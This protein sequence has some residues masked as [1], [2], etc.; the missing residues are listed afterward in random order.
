MEA[1]TTQGSKYE[2]VLRMESVERIQNLCPQCL[3]PRGKMLKFESGG[4]GLKLALWATTGVLNLHH[5]LQQGIIEKSGSL[6]YTKQ[7]VEIVLALKFWY[8]KE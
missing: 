6:A 8:H 5:S 3:F 2:S 4:G 7:N 1:A